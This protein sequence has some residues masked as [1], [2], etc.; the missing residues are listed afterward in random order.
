MANLL[1][2]LDHFSR[3]EKQRGSEPHSRI[4]AQERRYVDVGDLNRNLLSRVDEIPRVP[5]GAV[6]IHAGFVFWI[7]VCRGVYDSEPCASSAVMFSCAAWPWYVQ[8]AD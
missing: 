1:P 5:A 3:I 6:E 8:Y 4:H 7:R 2:R